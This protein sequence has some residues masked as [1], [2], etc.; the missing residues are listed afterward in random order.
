LAP[1]GHAEVIEKR[2]GIKPEEFDR[3]FLA[4]LEAETKKTVAG[5]ER[6]ASG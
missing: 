5:F 3:R 4:A 1:R 6:G 2:L